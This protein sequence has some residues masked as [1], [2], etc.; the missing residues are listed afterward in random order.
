[1][2]D[3][4]LFQNVT[5]D[6]NGRRSGLKHTEHPE[7][8]DEMKAS[9]REFNNFVSR[10]IIRFNNSSEIYKLKTKGVNNNWQNSGYYNPYF[11][12]KILLYDNDYDGVIIWFVFN[13]EGLRISIGT[14]GTLESENS[15]LATRIN[16]D[17][18]SVYINNI[19]GFEIKMDNIY[20]SYL[21]T[22]D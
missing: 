11:W 1:M 6:I 7:F 5:R 14:T 15:I 19:D 2:L 17:F 9:V 8:I 10:V 13:I 4:K 3:S 21:Y 12:N 22:R 16:D 20:T 18:K